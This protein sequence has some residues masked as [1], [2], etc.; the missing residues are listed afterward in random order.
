MSVPSV[1]AV[2]IHGGAGVHADRVYARAETHMSD[3][4]RIAA[5][6]LSGGAT[7]LDVVEVAV[8]AMETSGL[9]VAGRGSAPNPLGWV[10]LDAGIMDGATRR[11]GAVAALQGV[12][13]P[14]NAARRVMERTSS[15]FLVGEGAG[16]FALEQ[17][18][19]PIK[20]VEAWRTE[21]DGFDPSD[22]DDGHGTV[23]AVALDR[24][25]RLAA[26]T[27][28]GGVY[29]AP[30]GRVG[31]T[32]IVGAGV[33]AD[34]AVAISCTGQGE[35]FLRIAAAHD[36]AARIKYGNQSLVA[37]GGAVLQSVAA[38]GGDGGLVAVT[39]T[40]QIITPFNTPGMKRAWA[41]SNEESRVG[42]VGLR[43][44]SV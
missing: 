8:A 37:A 1:W 34:E 28:T 30:P 2:A 42:S 23:G 3:V 11:A 40:G 26:A 43:T 15:V 6:A 12:A 22:L 27:S 16:R 14:V 20:D 18:L 31:D 9:Y 33:W 39:R 19:E 25:G 24:Q 41:S 38:L 36:L 21:P 35:A 10:E 17:G 13:S 7:A 32:P 5:K 44:R 29:G 4:I